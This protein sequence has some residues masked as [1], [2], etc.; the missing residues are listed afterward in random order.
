[1]RKCC[2]CPEAVPLSLI[3]QDPCLVPP[4]GGNF[5][6]WCTARDCPAMPCEQC[7]TGDPPQC[8]TDRQV[9]YDEQPGW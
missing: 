5:P 9:C 8:D 6:Q 3:E 7:R 2:P 1:M 4:D